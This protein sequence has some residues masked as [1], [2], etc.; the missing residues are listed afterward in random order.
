MANEPQTEIPPALSGA[1]WIIGGSSQELPVFRKVFELKQPAENI[2]SA[3]ASIC[4]LG[5]YQLDINGQTVS[6]PMSP[7]WTNYRKTCLFNQWDV[8]KQLRSGTN[9]LGVWLGNGFFNVKGG[10]Y[11]KFT[12]SFGQP[13]WIGRLDI[14]FK[15]GSRQ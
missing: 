15:D 12:G 6:A 13:Q 7:G 10:R 1:D 9:V 2:D 4:G 5:F 8:K 14:T 3:T 11:V